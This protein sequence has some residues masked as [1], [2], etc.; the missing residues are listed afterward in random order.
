MQWCE[1]NI[2][3]QARKHICVDQNRPVV[4]RPAMNDAMTD[5]DELYAWRL[6]Q[7]F[8]GDRG[9]R[10]YVSDFSRWIRV[11][12]KEGSVRCFGAQSRTCAN[13]VYL[14]F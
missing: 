4:V 3:L 13:S 11:V 6:A 14:S 1:R 10:G 9:C 2:P 12:D 5:R 7:P 8:G